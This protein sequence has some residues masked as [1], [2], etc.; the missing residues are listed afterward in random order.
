MYIKK[1]TA[2]ETSN[3]LR[4]KILS[5]HSYIHIYIGLSIESKRGIHIYI[6][7]DTHPHASTL[8]RPEYIKKDCAI[9]QQMPSW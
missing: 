2:L 5:T 9:S 7:T 8:P 1:K 6:S 3:K 4:E